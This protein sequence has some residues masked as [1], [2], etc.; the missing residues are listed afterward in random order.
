MKQRGISTAW[1]EE[2]LQNPGQVVPG[3]GGRNIYQKL[4]EV[5]KGKQQLLRVVVEEG[6]GA[7]VV[8]AYLTSEI[9]RYWRSA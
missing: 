5:G 4:Y 3:Y 8:T 1:V 2:T 6:N 7:T 9:T